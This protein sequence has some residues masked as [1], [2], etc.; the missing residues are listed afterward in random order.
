MQTLDMHFFHSDEMR[1]M[2]LCHLEIVEYFSS[3]I[4]LEIQK[5][6]CNFNMIEGLPGLVSSE[7]IAKTSAY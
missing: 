1:K 3:V 6:C 5:L 4:R 7:S 2:K